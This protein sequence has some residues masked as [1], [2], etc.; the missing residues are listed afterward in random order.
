M[1]KSKRLENDMYEKESILLE[2]VVQGSLNENLS[3]DELHSKLSFLIK[4]YGKLLKLIRKITKVGDANQRKLVLAYDE[5]EKQKKELDSAYYK[6]DLL[7][8]KDPLTQLS[9]RRDFLEKVNTEMVRFERDKKEFAFVLSDIDDFKSFNDKY[10]HDCGDFVLKKVSEV[11]SKTIR[12]QDAVGRWGGEEFIL[13][14]PGSLADG[15]I[16]IAEIIRKAIS[17][18]TYVYGDLKLSITMTFGVSIYDG[19]GDIDSCIKE[20]DEALYLGKQKG[21]N[22]VIWR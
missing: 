1:I 14:L 21:K 4:S 22:C 10:G 5:I 8:R 3:K 11:F 9:N 15:A 6:L 18:Q 13:L 16:K 2:N 19:S 17:E 20:A 7:A 12:K